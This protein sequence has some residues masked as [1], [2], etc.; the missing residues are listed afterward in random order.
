MN[1]DSDGTAATKKYQATISA[2][3]ALSVEESKLNQEGSSFGSQA[4][5]DEEEAPPDARAV[6][7]APGRAQSHFRRAGA[8]VAQGA[9]APE[10]VRESQNIRAADRRQARS[11]ARSADPHIQDGRQQQQHR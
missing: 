2:S 5:L 8:V 4:V 3:G 7:A 10:A 6:A 11:A 9:A 1:Y